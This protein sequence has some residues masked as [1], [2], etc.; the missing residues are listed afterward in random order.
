MSWWARLLKKNTPPRDFAYMERVSRDGARS[1]V[2]PSGEELPLAP[3]TFNA[4]GLATVHD[5]SFLRDERFSAAYAAGVR[6]GHRITAPDKLHIECRDYLRCWAASHALRIT[7]D[8]VE[9][10]V[11]TGIVSMALCRCTGL[12]RL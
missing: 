2:L 12:Q 11:R 1:R 9:C 3:Y 7:S 6:T 5:A 10:G 4:D 8:F